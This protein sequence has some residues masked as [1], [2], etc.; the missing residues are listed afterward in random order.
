MRWLVALLMLLPYQARA[1]EEAIRAV[2]LNN[3]EHT[4][5][6]EAAH[7][8]ISEFELPVIG[9]EEDAAD[10][11]AT[12]W[13]LADED[14]ERLERLLDVAEL[15]LI[16]HELSEEGGEAPIYYGEHD[17]DAQRGL[18]VLCFIA[19]EGPGRAHDLISEWGLPQD[20]AESCEY[21]YELAL[22]GWEALLE[23]FWLPED[24]RPTRIRVR[25]GQG[26]SPWREILEQDGLLDYVAES[27]AKTYDLDRG[28]TVEASSCGEANAFWDPQDRKIM[29][30]YELLDLY[31]DLARVA[32][33]G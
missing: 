4:L 13:M 24:T 22:E 12:L 1:D 26:D 32:V 8:L 29:L 31:E 5:W 10:T 15:W 16:S 17:L 11:F 6:H 33:E 28:L 14:A 20:R 25:Y 3:A 9:Q 27:L 2:V 30:C 23:P 19:G 21:D 7:A 18:R